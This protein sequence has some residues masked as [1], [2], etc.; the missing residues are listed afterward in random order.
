MCSEAL[1]PAAWLEALELRTVIAR[2]A[3]DLCRCTGDDFRAGCEDYPP[4]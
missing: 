1:L 3:D 2:L 4:N